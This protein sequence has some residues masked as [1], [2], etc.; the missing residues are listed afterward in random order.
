[1]KGEDYGYHLVCLNLTALLLAFNEYLGCF[2]DY[3]FSLKLFSAL[4][5]VYLVPGSFRKHLI[6]LI[7][8]VPDRSKN[9]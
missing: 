3:P 2:I 7:K 4:T 8:V 5:L 1:L 6:S 9:N